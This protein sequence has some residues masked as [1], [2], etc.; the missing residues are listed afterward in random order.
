MVIPTETVAE[1]SH[2]TGSVEPAEEPAAKGI[3]CH[4]TGNESKGNQN[5]PVVPKY[6]QP[7]SSRIRVLGEIVGWDVVA[8]FAEERAAERVRA[9]K[10]RRHYALG[11]AALRY[12]RRR[13]GA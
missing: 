4:A 2:P 6:G 11:A 5:M 7:T 9:A 10:F 12:R 8:S 1:L 3:A 13:N